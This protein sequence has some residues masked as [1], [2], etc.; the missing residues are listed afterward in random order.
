MSQCASLSDLGYRNKGSSA[1]MSEADLAGRTTGIP[2]SYSEMALSPEAR[3]V[4]ASRLG[5]K[6][7]EMLEKG[8]KHSDKKK[9][10]KM[11]YL[12]LFM[13]FIIIA[14]IAWIILYAWKPEIVQQTDRR[15]NPKG[16]ADGV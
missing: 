10:R 5:T 2:R 1:T 6:E 3:A 16:E 9:S 11:S 8:Q 4:E 12:T 14:I 7:Y 15:G 13:W